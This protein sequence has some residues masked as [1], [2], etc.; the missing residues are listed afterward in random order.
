MNGWGRDGIDWVCGSIGGLS[1][2]GCSYMYLIS[3]AFAGLLFY[4]LVLTRRVIRSLETGC[5]ILDAID[6]PN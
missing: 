2:G 5:R 4:T 1:C 3:E 6:V